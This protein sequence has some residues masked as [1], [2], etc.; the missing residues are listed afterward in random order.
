MSNLP[1]KILLA[2]D[3][4]EDAALAARVA[5]DLSKRCGAELHVVHVWTAIPSARFKAFIRSQLEQAARELLDSEV[6]RLG[7]SGAKVTQAHL[8]EGRS[9]DEIVA[10]ADELGADLVILGSRGLGTV[11]RLVLGSVSEGVVHLSSRPTLIVRGGEGAWPPS[12]VVVGDDGSVEA[13]KAG[14]LAARM[15]GLFGAQVVLVRVYPPQF[16]YKSVT[17]PGFGS[18]EAS[19]ESGEESL[20]QRACELEELG[21][22]RPRVKVAA[23]DA[24]AVIQETAE[25][26][27]K[28][29]LVAVGARGLGAAERFTLG[30]ISTDLLGAADGPVLVVPLGG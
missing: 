30:S 26:L 16:I 28:P 13:T 22:G 18:P 5:A 9:A 6:E 3:G 11:K 15:G 10:L 2:T 20:R 14:E 24:A 27:G 12:A 8:R 29:T 25:E 17:T 19:L 4:S 21:G 7:S 1:T 23:G